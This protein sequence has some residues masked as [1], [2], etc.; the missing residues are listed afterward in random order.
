MGETITKTLEATLAPP[1]AH[2]ER[3]LQRTTATYRR[4][5]RAAFESGAKTQSAVNDIVTEYRLTSY[6]KDALKS[7]VPQLRQT[8]SAAEL[9]DDHPVRFTNRGWKLDRSKDR[10]HEFCWRVPQAG[11]GNSFWIPLR[12]NPAQREL[13]DDLYQGNMTVGE[14]RLQEC[15][16]NWV[17][18][19]TVEYDAP[20]VDRETDQTPVGFDIGESKLL[21]GCAYQDGKPTQPM[22]FDGGRARQLRKEMFTTLRRLETRGADQKIDERRDYFQ[23]ALTD[24]VEK[25]S[26]R[27]VE[28]AQQFEDPIIVLEDLTNIRESIDYGK[29]MNRRLHT[30]AFARLTGRIEDKAREEGIPV[31]FVNPAYTSQI[32][33]ACGH[34][35]ARPSQAEFHCT[36]S[37][38]WVTEFQAD[39]NASANVAAR[40][41]PWGESVPWE[42]DRDDSP[43]DGSAS[44]SAAGHREPSPRSGQ[45]K[46]TAFSS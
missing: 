19:V 12:I 15:R 33:H 10:T 40:V 1:T 16:T 17:L 32:C 37:A 24:I 9:D 22:L 31:Q 7:R 43:R 30:W 14:F 39:I 5:L 36:N 38:C 27:A 18:H 6:A 26:R 13:W 45:M 34:L 4:A 44:D 35:G 3:R 8:H 41:D 28:Y 23:N 11:W 46:L 2:K 29:W 25:A 21:T 42:P 20:E